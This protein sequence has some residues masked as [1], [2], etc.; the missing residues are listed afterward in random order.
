MTTFQKNYIGKGKRVK[1]LDIVR[2]S[3]SRAKLE[4]ALKSDLVKYDDNEYLV[5]EVA[6]LKAKDDYGR[7]HTA[8]IS[9]KVEGKPRSKKK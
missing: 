8:Y 9:K 6:G 7:T 2:V 4:E 1:D 5:F 3:I